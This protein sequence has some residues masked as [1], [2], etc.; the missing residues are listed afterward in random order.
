MD[1]ADE[2]SVDARI[3]SGLDLA[4]GEDDRHRQAPCRQLL[5]GFVAP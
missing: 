2:S 1:S 5:F 3:R 4:Q